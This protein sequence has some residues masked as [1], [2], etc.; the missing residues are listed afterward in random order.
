MRDL[1]FCLAQPSQS[2][3]LPY[4]KISRDIH[5]QRNK[6]KGKLPMGIYLRGIRLLFAEFRNAVRQ[7]GMSVGD[8]LNGFEGTEGVLAG[9]GNVEESILIFM[10]LINR[11][12][13]RGSR[14]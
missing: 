6:V 8:D 1:C 11:T 10:L 14:G 3:P 2:C 5:A 12:H 13:Q 7:I 9:V 4:H